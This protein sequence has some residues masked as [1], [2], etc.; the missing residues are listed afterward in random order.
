MSLAIL[1][2]IQTLDVDSQATFAE[3]GKP[4]TDSQK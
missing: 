2:Q 4:F 3:A 1:D